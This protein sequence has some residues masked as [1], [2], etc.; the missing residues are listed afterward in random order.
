MKIFKR[1]VIGF[2]GLIL[3]CCIFVLAVSFNLKKILVNG[4]IKETIVQSVMPRSYSEE[5]VVISDEQIK[6][7]TDDP[8]IQEILKS[9]EIQDLMEKYLDSTVN[10]LIDEGNIDEIALEQDMMNFLKEN[11]SVIE[12]KVGKE[13]TDEMI[14]N[15]ASQL[16]TQDMTRAYKTAVTNASRTMSSTEKEVLRGYRLLISDIFRIII[17]VLMIIDLIIIAVIQLSLHQWIGTLAVSSIVAGISTIIA[18]I[19]TKRIVEEKAH[20]ANFD[21]SSLTT[22]GIIILIVGIIVLVLYKLIVK[23]CTKKGDKN[24]ISK[25]SKT[26]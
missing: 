18:S 26:E 12:E 23:L 24:G 25:V 8:R 9:P 1:I 15:A 14:E 21:T 20:F 4:V 16:E 3:V 2:L 13:V 10:G 5:K 6:E 22:T 19:A 11:R 17:L 7:I